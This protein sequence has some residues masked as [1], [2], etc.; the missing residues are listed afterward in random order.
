MFIHRQSALAGNSGIHSNSSRPPQVRRVAS[1]LISIS[2]MCLCTFISTPDWHFHHNYR[3]N[4]LTTDDSNLACSQNSPAFSFCSFSVFNVSAGNNST[5]AGERGQRPMRACGCFCVLRG[6]LGV[7]VQPVLLI[8]WDLGSAALSWK[9]I[10]VAF[11]GYSSE[12][13]ADWQ[14]SW[15]TDRK[16][17]KCWQGRGGRGWGTGDR[18]AQY[19]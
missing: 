6:N 19:L 17:F 16:T 9:I 4:H 13:N 14:E 10:G 7:C 18:A 15:E 2:W 1:R 3:A 5:S 11:C 8:C 12:Y